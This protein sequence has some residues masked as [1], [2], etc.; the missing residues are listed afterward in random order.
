MEDRPVLPS[1][2]PLAKK[3]LVSTERKILKDK[4]VAIA[5]QQVLDD[6]VDKKYLSCSSRRT[7]A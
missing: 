5:Y 3:R 4:E 2:S 1:N 6:Y 7:K